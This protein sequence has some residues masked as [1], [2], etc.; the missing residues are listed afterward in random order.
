MNDL[1]FISLPIYT[2]ATTSTTSSSQPPPPSPP[3]TTPPPTVEN[4]PK[5]PASP[6]TIP[7]GN[8]CFRLLCHASR[9]D[10]VMGIINHLQNE[11]SAKVRV[12]H[13]P[14]SSV[15]RVISIVGNA[16][17]D[18]I[19]S[20]NEESEHVHNSDCCDVSEAQEALVRVYERVL[21]VTAENDGEGYFGNYGNVEGGVVSCRLLTDMSLV[22]LVI[23][24]GG[25]VV[26]KIRM[27]TGCKITV[28]RKISKNKLPTCALPNDELIEIEGEFIAVKKALVAVTSRLQ[29]SPPLG[30]P[31]RVSGR[32]YDGSN[33]EP[34]LPKGHGHMDFPPA[35]TLV[36]EPVPT[37]NCA[38]GNRPSGPLDS[39][40]FQGQHEIVFWILC[41]G[42]RIGGVIGNSG[43]IIKALEKESGASIS[44]QSP[45]YGYHE[46]LITIRAFEDNPESQNSPAQNAVML[47]FNRLRNDIISGRN[48]SG[49]KT[50]GQ[51]NGQPFGQPPF[52]MHPSMA[53]HH[54]I[55]QH[56]AITQRMD[57]LSLRNN[58][59]H[60]SSSGPWQSQARG[61]SFMNGHDVN[62]GPSS[63][64]GGIEL[65]RGGR[66]AIVTSATVKIAVPENVIELV[67]GEK[68]SNLTRIRQILLK[69]LKKRGK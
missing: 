65:G 24:R 2:A 13:A 68:G 50:Y 43:T 32:P 1:P 53:G 46:Q 61:G 5:T 12:E 10:G 36:Q 52:G 44:I 16:A 23:G 57:N 66:S 17:V 18:R 19:M 8:T 9:I 63:V 42:D 41:P 58:A 56:A 51:G 40:T 25:K 34:T 21:G 11:T 20:V 47:V 64:K 28:Y 15:D 49:L 6:L 31:R 59:D 26:E 54:H 60:P 3:S 35:G 37:T 38:T 4:H 55:N 7:T 39:E 29:E 14:P 33:H 48:S 22:G 30:K 27:E 62:R 67:Y 45:G 69:M